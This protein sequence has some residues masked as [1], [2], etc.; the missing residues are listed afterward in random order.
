MADVM[1]AESIRK[2]SPTFWWLVAS[3]CTA[4]VSA[5]REKLLMFKHV[6]AVWLVS[7]GQSM[8]LIVRTWT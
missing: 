8:V 3:V 1:M 7:G 5:E 4:P 6:S 2:R